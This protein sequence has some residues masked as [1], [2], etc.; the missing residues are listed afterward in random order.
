MLNN[1][2]PLNGNPPAP[3]GVDDN[4]IDPELLNQQAPGMRADENGH[5]RRRR[6][7]G[8]EDEEERV[9]RLSEFAEQSMDR[10][11]LQGDRRGAVRKFA[12][13]DNQQMLIELLVMN[14]SKEQKV[15]STA[16]RDFL[17]MP[18]YTK[19]II[20]RLKVALLAPC[21]MFYVT[22]LQEW[23][24]ADIQRNPVPWGMPLEV[25]NDAAQW[26]E[27][28]PT[29]RTKLTGLRSTFKIE[30]AAGA[31]K[32]WDINKI[33][34][35][36]ALKQMMISEEHRA[37]WAFVARCLSDFRAACEL[38][39]SETREFWDYVDEQLDQA[40]KE[41]QAQPNATTPA[42]RQQL[43]A[44]LFG[45]VLAEHRAQYPAKS[46]VGALGDRPSWQESLEMP[47]DLGAAV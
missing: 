22:P 38:E 13:L 21:I 20:T 39:N 40:K 27:F 10:H 3:P 46:A 16:A 45:V 2:P 36:L 19:G 30:L 7:S 14:M 15:S 11:N 12:K 31:D 23:I 25:V 43:L 35:R 4:M 34:C 1:V 28:A 9:A 33:T 17:K 8:S 42:I 37:R 32:N 26:S 24:L 6:D 5:R 29:L 18:A 47:M 44:G 41:V